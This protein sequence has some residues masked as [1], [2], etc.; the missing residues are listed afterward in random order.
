MAAITSENVP[1]C[2][3]AASAVS[4]ASICA[5]YTFV[6]HPGGMESGPAAYTAFFTKVSENQLSEVSACSRAQKQ[7]CLPLAKTGFAQNMGSFLQLLAASASVLWQQLMSFAYAAMPSFDGIWVVGEAR[8]RKT[9][10]FDSSNT[11]YRLYF[12]GSQP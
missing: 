1:G 5:C 11:M 10:C 8:K 4:F 12:L 9:H 7:S 3:A 6:I 2:I